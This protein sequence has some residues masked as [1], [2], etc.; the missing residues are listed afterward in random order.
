[1]KC[2]KLL[3]LEAE[4]IQAWVGKKPRKEERLTRAIFDHYDGCAICQ[5]DGAEAGKNTRAAP[6]AK[7]P[8]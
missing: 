6:S 8:A 1:M 4:A 2:P 7:G 3:A 5:K